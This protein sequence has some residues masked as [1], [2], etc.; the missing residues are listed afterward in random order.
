MEFLFGSTDVTEPSGLFC[1]RKELAKNFGSTFQELHKQ[2][3][4]TTD[5]FVIFFFGIGCGLSWGGKRMQF[6]G[7][8]L[9][10]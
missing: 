9:I 5:L 8:F 10:V 2:M 6:G 3:K 1:F 4:R 7:S